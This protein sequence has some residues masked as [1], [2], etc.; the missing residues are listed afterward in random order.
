MAQCWLSI[1][2]AVC[3]F[4]GRGPGHG[5]A[6]AFVQGLPRLCLDLL[7]TQLVHIV[8][9][10]DFLVAVMGEFPPPCWPLIGGLCQHL[11]YP[12]PRRGLSPSSLVLRPYSCWL[13]QVAWSPRR[14]NPSLWPGSLA[15]SHSHSKSILRGKVTVG[16]RK[17]LFIQ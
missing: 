15:L 4:P 12:P 9:R 5:I 13:L 7:E 17:Y 3:H 11:E 1:A 8:G 10:G 14:E 2:T 6:G 16:H